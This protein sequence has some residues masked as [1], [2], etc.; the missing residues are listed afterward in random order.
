MKPN[1][2]HIWAGASDQ[3]MYI[4]IS[5]YDYVMIRLISKN[6]L[7][8][9]AKCLYLQYALTSYLTDCS[10]FN[11]IHVPLKFIHVLYG[12]FNEK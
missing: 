4:E 5:K 6:I 1:S 8:T 11:L 9:R 2:A 12:Q 7:C 10:V 3:R